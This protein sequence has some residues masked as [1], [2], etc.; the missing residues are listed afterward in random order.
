M[1][2]KLTVA[3]AL[4]A[5][6][7]APYR[8]AGRPA[9]AA[10]PPVPAGVQ[11]SEATWT[12]ARGTTLF[13][14]TWRPSGETPVRGVLVV[15]HGLKDHSDHY[16]PLA[17]SLVARG[18]AVRAF[19]L[20]GHGA[21]EGRRVR[22]KRFDDYVDDLAAFVARVRTEYP[23]KPVFVMGHSMGGAIAT[24]YAIDRQPQISGLILSG[25]ALKVTRDVN[26]FKRGATKATA[27]LFPGAPVF[28]LPDDKFSRDASVVAAMKTDPLVYDKA[29]AAK[30]AAEVL[31]AI[32]RI[33]AGMQ[34]VNVPLLALHGGADVVTN[35]KGSRALVER[36]ATRDKTLKIYDGAYHDLL[37]DDAREAV[38]ADLEAWLETHTPQS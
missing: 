6:G 13:E 35:P 31:R 5:G 12:G 21:S 9:G 30:T 19:D 7:C 20:R 22:V 3:F 27:A 32:G 10:A 33:Q 16:A 11:H 4:V 37:H 36:A 15:M 8:A 38:R 28:T 17:S 34:K 14:Q 25:P 1:K 26:A 29:A 23:D 18:F 24:L 2:L